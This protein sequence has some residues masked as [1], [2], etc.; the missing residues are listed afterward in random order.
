MSQSY[1]CRITF[2][3]RNRGSRCQWL[4]TEILLKEP[5]ALI[6]HRHKK[7]QWLK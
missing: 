7:G 4:L 6:K 1:V 2:C 3:G 5:R